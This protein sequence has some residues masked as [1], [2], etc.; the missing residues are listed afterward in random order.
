MSLCYAVTYTC[1]CCGDLKILKM[2][3]CSLQLYG[4]AYLYL[5]V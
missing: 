4:F 3:L 5:F 2:Q 1:F